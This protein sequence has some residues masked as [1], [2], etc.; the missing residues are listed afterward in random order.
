VPTSRETLLREARR[1]FAERG[2]AAT[3]VADVQA[4]AGLAPGSG[5][6]YKHFPSK[7]A[8]L[9]A[10]LARPAELPASLPDDA[11]PALASLG[12]HLLGLDALSR[13][14]LPLGDW[15]R[16]EVRAG[17]LRD[18]D[19]E[20]VAVALVGALAHR[21]AAA[22]LLGT[23]PADEPSEERLLDAWVDL[24]VTALDPRRDGD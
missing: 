1:L 6:L 3:S 2:Y 5:A 16:A 15:L 20:A 22:A 21:R 7:R 19:C 12:R 23:A 10:A 4:A 8:L 17:R 18:H 9:E 24:V 11:E 14:E 13:P